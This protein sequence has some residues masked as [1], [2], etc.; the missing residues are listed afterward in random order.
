MVEAL[1]G[2]WVSDVEAASQALLDHCRPDPTQDVDDIAIMVVRVADGFGATADLTVNVTINPRIGP[3]ATITIMAGDNQSAPVNL[4]VAVAPSV[5]VQDSLGNAVADGT[6]V[7]FAVLA[8]G[9]SITGEIAS[10]VNG[11][12]TLGSWKLGATPGANG[13]AETP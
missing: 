8:G 7:T 4:A 5:L 1:A 11:V 10:T 3:P 2:P 12:A 9:G 13:H 6:T